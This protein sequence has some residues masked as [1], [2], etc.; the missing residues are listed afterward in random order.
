MEGFTEWEYLPWGVRAGGLN[1]LA[2][3]R[4]DIAIWNAPELLPHLDASEPIV[5]L[6]GVHGG[7]YQLFGG[8]RVNALRDLKGKT[9]GDSL[10]WERGSH[11]ALEHAGVR[12]D[13]ATQDVNWITGGDLRN[14]MNLFTA[15][16]QMLSSA[17]PRSPQSSGSR[18][19]GG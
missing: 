3:G 11:I 6:S 12:G 18:R 14:A 9:C 7:C 13:E 16:R 19:S 1:A 4:A 5:V 8:E 2:E 17:M 10:L 15:A